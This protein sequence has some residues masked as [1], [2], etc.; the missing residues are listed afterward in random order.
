ML[1]VHKDGPELYEAMVALPT[2]SDL[3]STGNFQLKKMVLGKILMAEIK[4]GEHTI[5]KGE[6][7]LTN[8]VN[9][10]KKISPAIPFQ[11]LVTNR[12]QESDTSK[13]VT[14]LYYPIFY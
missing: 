13:W 4:G 2:K 5:I 10:Y 8:Y 14:R 11:S 6:E 7:E 1:N 3:L 12:Q 9:D